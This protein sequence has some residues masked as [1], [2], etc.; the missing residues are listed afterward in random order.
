MSKPENVDIAKSKKYFVAVQQMQYFEIVVE[1][2]D[3]PLTEDTFWEEYYDIG[4]CELDSTIVE[5]ETQKII[6]I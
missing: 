3:L 5:M 2:E 1:E 4:N 6:N